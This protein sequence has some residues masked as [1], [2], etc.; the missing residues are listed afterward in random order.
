VKERAATAS[1][2]IYFGPALSRRP[3]HL[4]S[5]AKSV[6]H[7]PNLACTRRVVSCFRHGCMLERGGLDVQ[8]TEDVERVLGW[9]MA[10]G[11][12]N[13]CVADVLRC[14]FKTNYNVTLDPERKTRCNG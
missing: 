5:L 7:S 12:Q 14:G 11:D 4:T 6:Q 13:S 3:S 10:M 8:N 1:N 9:K 2:R